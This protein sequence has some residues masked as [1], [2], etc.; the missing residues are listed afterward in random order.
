MELLFPFPCLSFPS[1]PPLVPPPPV[2]TCLPSPP[3]PFVFLLPLP[4]FSSRLGPDDYHEPLK[5]RDDMS[6][7]FQKDLSDS[8][9]NGLEGYET[10]PTIKK[11]GVAGSC[12]L[13]T[14]LKSV[15]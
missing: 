10:R 11:K 9:V 2:L 4:L 3:S 6:F 8:L 14:Y 1:L 15:T 5:L 12:A 7:L 13:L